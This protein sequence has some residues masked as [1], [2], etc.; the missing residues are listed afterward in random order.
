[1]ILLC[2]MNSFFASVHQ[3]MRPELRGKPIIVAGDPQK[4]R[5]IVVAASYEAKAYGVYTTMRY[6]DAWKCCPKAVFVRPEHA[7]YRQYSEAI[8]RFLARIAPCEVA[9]IDEAYLDITEIIERGHSPK[10]VT[11]YIQHKL[12]SE[13]RIPCSIGAGPNK[14][15]AKMCADVKKP[16]GFVEMGQRQFQAYFWPQPVKRLHGCGKSTAE[17]LN[18]KGIHTIGQLAAHPVEDLQQWFGKKGEYLYKAA[19]GAHVSPVN[20]ERKKGEKSI[21]SS[22]TFAIDTMEHSLIEQ[23]AREFSHKLAEKVQRQHKR[24]AT[25]SVEVKFDYRQ[26][27]SR[28][29]TLEVPTDRADDIYR[30]AMQTYELHFSDRPIRLFGIR[31]SNLT[32]QVYEQLKFSF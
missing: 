9:S 17:K 20:P 14:L 32:A 5:G 3:S 6:R 13:L 18:Q 28:S 2:D 29:I 12:E 23:T 10:E 21:G 24:A 26:A 19:W 22:R 11:S 8:M 7:L 30:I 4:R 1:M 31:L 15:I 25:V 27:V 16:R